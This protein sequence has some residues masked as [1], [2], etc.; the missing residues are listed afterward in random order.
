MDSGKPFGPSEPIVIRRLHRLTQLILRLCGHPLGYI[1][2]ACFVLPQF[3]A[4]LKK[5]N[6][7]GSYKDSLK[8]EFREALEPR[9]VESVL[10]LYDKDDPSKHAQVAEA[11]TDISAM[12][13]H[14]FG[15]TQYQHHIERPPS[16]KNASPEDILQL[17]H[18][19]LYIGESESIQ[20]AFQRLTLGITK[21]HEALD[22]FK[23]ELHERYGGTVFIPEERDGRTNPSEE[24]PP[25]HPRRSVSPN[26]VGTTF[27]EY[28]RMC[29]WIEEMQSRIAL[30]FVV[31]DCVG[32]LRSYIEVLKQAQS[33]R[34]E[35]LDTQWKVSNSEWGIYSSTRSIGEKV[36]QIVDKYPNA[37]IADLSSMENSW[38]RTPNA[39]AK[40]GTKRQMEDDVRTVVQ[41]ASIESETRLVEELD[42]MLDLYHKQMS[43][44]KEFDVG[45]SNLLSSS[46]ASSDNG[47]H[48]IDQYFER[49]K[50]RSTKGGT[51]A[52][53][54][55]QMRRR[56]F[57][58]DQQLRH[59]QHNIVEEKALKSMHDENAMLTTELVS[60]TDSLKEAS[61]S[62]GERIRRDNELLESA[63]SA[64]DTNIDSV[65]KRRAELALQLSGSTQ[66]FGGTCALLLTISCVW[67][68]TYFL[69]KVVPPG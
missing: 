8:E 57:S 65:R 3:D 63:S 5:H 62:L 39:P 22:K 29:W 10:E 2:A 45:N 4:E 13:V 30:L 12:T 17:K 24:M 27:H 61:E 44:R 7:N 11:F 26:E 32:Q 67:I 47:A 64:A 40:N 1:S 34:M 52:P 20:L 68:A 55:R 9:T 36:C 23:E 60:M 25:N 35:V 59:P 43:L 46:K 49:T 16:E 50:I 28:L 6:E 18:P 37:E 14:A 38:D 31:G 33:E 53:S 41:Q 21:L 66:T 69:I 48:M 19:A 15:M 56:L 58:S 51:E 42:T 54:R